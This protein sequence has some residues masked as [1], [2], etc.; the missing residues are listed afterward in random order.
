MLLT[1]PFKKS[2]GGCRWEY[3]DGVSDPDAPSMNLGDDDT[4]LEEDSD[5]P[6]SEENEDPESEN[7]DP[8][9]LS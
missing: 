9:S 3:F 1:L 7:A 6:E 2:V 4:D 8:P 5:E